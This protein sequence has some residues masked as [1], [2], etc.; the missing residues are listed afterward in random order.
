MKKFTRLMGFVLA[1]VMLF[2]VSITGAQED[3]KV[4]NYSFGPGDIPSLDPSLGTDTSSIQVVVELFPGLTRL[5]EVT[6]DIDPGMADWEVSEDGL[7]YTFSLLEEVPWVQYDAEADAVVEATDAD[8]NVRF[9]TAE[10]FRYGMLRSMDARTGSYYGGILSAWVAGG[11]AL[12]TAEIGEDMSDEAA[13]E[14]IE[15]LMD[16]VGI[17]AVDDYTLEVDVTTP[18]AFLP[19]IFGMWMATAQPQWVV[20]EFGDFWTEPENIVTFGP[21]ALK[22]WLHGESITMVKNPFWAGTDA[23]PAPAIDEVFATMLDA[24]PQLANYEAGSLDIADVPLA[25][26]D[27]IQADP[28]L[29]A[30]LSIGEGS[31]TY[32]YIFNTTKAPFDDVRVR[33]AFSLALDR[34]D[35]IDNVLQGGQA[36]AAFFSRP[37]LIAAPT[38]E[39][40]PDFV[41]GEDLDRAIELLDEYRAEVGELPAISLWH[42]ESSGHAAIAAAAIDMWSDLDV[43][44]S[45]QTQEWAVY[46]DTIKSDETAPQVFRYAWCLDYPDTHNFLYD[47]FHSSVRELG[48]GYD[49]GAEIDPLL[50]A[51]LV[52]TDTE[53]RQALYAEA[54]YIFATRDAVYAPI[55]YY[56]SLSLTKPNVERTYS[57]IG[58]QRFE[59]WNIVD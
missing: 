9:V 12:N 31:C 59:K 8:G 56:T 38:A 41:L 46:L 37:N 21:F 25:D 2:A 51:A 16:E 53:A 13:A 45:T 55:Y 1:I 52:E 36:P 24:E 32:M 40:Y 54:E 20:E 39:D 29:S 17:R 35:I 33:Q 15:G 34:Q 49:T 4:L 5:D 3:R 58:T 44:V 26:I 42:N 19:N 47:V 28:T 43:E 7:T 50:E 48:I 18:A 11:E 22:A 57:V 23:I 14:M 30:E 6:L 10:D 27:R